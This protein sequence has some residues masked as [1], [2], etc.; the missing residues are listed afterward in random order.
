MK[1]PFSPILRVDPTDGWC[2]RRGFNVM[3]SKRR[4]VLDTMREQQPD[5]V[6]LHLCADRG[7]SGRT[8]NQ[9][10]VAEKRARLK[11]RQ[12]VTRAKSQKHVCPS[13][14]THATR[15]RHSDPSPTGS[16]QSDSVAK[17][18]DPPRHAVEVHKDPN[19][20]RSVCHYKRNAVKPFR[21]FTEHGEVLE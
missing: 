12:L 15:V 11:I 7:P 16:L 19:R 4:M 1:R 9:K 5:V 10:I 17:R 6:F 8:S 18:K 21:T 3:T 14:E 2:V 13:T 20:R